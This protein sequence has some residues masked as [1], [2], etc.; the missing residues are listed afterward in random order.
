MSLSIL[1]LRFSTQFS[2]DSLVDWN[3]HLS[4]ARQQIKAKNIDVQRII[5]DDRH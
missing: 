5:I 2:N 4:D 1:R 3:N